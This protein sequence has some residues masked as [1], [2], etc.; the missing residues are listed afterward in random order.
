MVV[1]TQNKGRE[2]T[3]LQVGSNNVRRYFPKDT[4]VVEL[5]LDHL[6]IQCR[7]EPDFW[8]DQPEIHDPRLGAW[9]ESKNLHVR[10]SCDPVPLALIPKG[11][12]SFLL[13]TI[14]VNNRISALRPQSR[15]ASDPFNAA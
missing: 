11:K 13:R 6:Q 7:L 9:L 10:P 8:R 1:K 12:N 3:G 2:I 4:A 15:P 5:Q 14:A